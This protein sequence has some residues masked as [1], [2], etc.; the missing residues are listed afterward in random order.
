M[1]ASRTW[2]LVAVWTVLTLAA[3][4]VMAWALLSSEPLAARAWFTPGP[5][6]HGH[7]SIELACGSCHV[8]AFGGGEVLETSCTGC[9][10][11]QLDAANDAHPRAK[12]TDPRNADL[13]N[14]IDARNCVSCHS[15]HRPEMTHPMGLTLPPDY[16]LTCHLDIGTERDTHAGLGFE[17]CASAGCHNYHDN[18]ALYAD[19]LLRHADDP[20]LTAMAR[21]PHRLPGAGVP[22]PL[23]SAAPLP[24][25]APALTGAAMDD[26][27]ASAHADAGMGCGSC[28]AAGG[29]WVQRPDHTACAGCHGDEVDGFL[30]GTHG[31]RLAVD[32]PPMTPAMA[33]LPMQAQ[34][35]HTELG[36]GSCHAA[37]RFDVHTA[38]VE[39]CLS[40][41]ADD[42]SLAY[43]GSPH[44]QLW[45]QEQAGE[46]PPGSG[47]S[48]ATCHL[49]RA[50]HQRAGVTTIRVQHNQN[51]GLRP[52]EAMVRPVCQN[53]HG[54]G[55]A[56]DALADPELIRRNFPHAPTH[57]V[58]SIDMAVRRAEA[59]RARR[60][61]DSS[62][63]P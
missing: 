27:L 54:L 52:N 2:R 45:Q 38:A 39:S 42:H 26:W 30:A 53:C 10:G 5:M 36:C 46:R 60:A 23:P 57:H 48:C 20:I 49:P 13:L 4:G 29:A 55:F 59:D 16:C 37:H 32:L 28:H 19:F 35:A 61:V 1:R 33:R 58:E 24:A 43:V 7:H 3:G 50:Q 11:A 18:R 31:M 56:L 6:T 41:H 51:D 9:H 62:P 12:F 8:D 63:G 44:H 22:Q 47:V 25:Q 40:C 14:V 34:A 21:V 15:E 17:T